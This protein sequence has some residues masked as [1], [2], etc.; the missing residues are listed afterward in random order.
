MNFYQ[1]YE[2]IDV[3]RSQNKLSMNIEQSCLIVIVVY[4]VVVVKVT[5]SFS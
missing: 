2:K 4:I 5:N 1:K 3:Q